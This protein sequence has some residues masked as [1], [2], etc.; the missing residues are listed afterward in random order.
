MKKVLYASLVALIAFS[1]CKKDE[2][3]T[4]P[5]NLTSRTWQ[6]TADGRTFK[7]KIVS[8]VFTDLIGGNLQLIGT[9]DNGST[10]TTFGLS[11]QFEG[12]KIDTGTFVTEDA[13]TNFSLVKSQSGD[14][15]YAANT[16]SVPPVL[17][18]KVSAYD[19]TT[20]VISGTFSGDC[21]NFDGAN[22]PVTNGTFK[23]TIK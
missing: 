1:A 13:G 21:Y 14:I 22:V 16:F 12:S 7:G 6:F 11:V 8:A 17:S 3:K 2:D 15:I 23:T 5:T 20:K 4:N 9:F 18:I 19:S 10:D